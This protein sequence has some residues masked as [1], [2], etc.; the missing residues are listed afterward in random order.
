MT[1][2]YQYRENSTVMYIHVCV[3]I[4]FTLYSNYQEIVCIL[5]EKN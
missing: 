4:Y 3:N 5:M 1:K 2:N